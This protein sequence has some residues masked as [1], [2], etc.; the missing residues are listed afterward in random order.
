MLRW[1]RCQKKMAGSLPTSSSR[2]PLRFLSPRQMSSRSQ[3]MN[4][5]KYRALVLE[6]PPC[7]PSLDVVAAAPT[8]LPGATAMTHRPY[9]LIRIAHSTRIHSVDSIVTSAP[10]ASVI[11][12]NDYVMHVMTV[13]HSSSSDAK[14]TRL[15]LVPDTPYYTYSPPMPLGHEIRYTKASRCPSSDGR[16]IPPFSMLVAA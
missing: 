5:T 6:T 8:R 1:S 7:V 4:L 11:L 3:T 14:L 12:G 13:F 2:Q 15:F 16:G 9:L 10:F